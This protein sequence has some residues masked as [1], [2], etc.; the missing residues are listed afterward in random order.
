MPKYSIRWPDGRLKRQLG[1]TTQREAKREFREV[2]GEFDPGAD[3]FDLC[4]DAWGDAENKIV[5]IYPDGRKR[6]HPTREPQGRNGKYDADAV[7]TKIVL[8]SALHGKL[9]RYCDRVG[10]SRQSIMSGAVAAMID[11]LPDVA[12]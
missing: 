7:S 1:A 2:C 12:Q 10:K 8:S 9:G 4:M 5:A 6:V 11:Q 3:Q